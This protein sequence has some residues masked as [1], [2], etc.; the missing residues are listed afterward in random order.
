MNTKR[1]LSSPRTR[2]GRR[3][4]SYSNATPRRQTKTRQERI[5][6]KAQLYLENIYVAIDSLWRQAYEFP[7]TFELKKV[8]ELFNWPAQNPPNRYLVAEDV[9]GKAL[10]YLCIRS[11][12]FL[13]LLNQTSN[14]EFWET[15]LRLIFESQTSL[16][17]FALTRGLAWLEGFTPEDLAIPQIWLVP[18]QVSHPHEV[19]RGADGSLKRCVFTDDNGSSFN[20]TNITENIYDETNWDRNLPK[21]RFWPEWQP[22]PGD[23]SICP[24]DGFG[25][26]ALCHGGCGGWTGISNTACRCVAERTYDHALVEIVQMTSYNPGEPN[27]AVRAVARIKK[28]EYIGEYCGVFIPYDTNDLPQHADSIYA[29][30][31][32][33][34][35]DFKPYTGQIILVNDESRDAEP[36]ATLIGGKY[37][38]WPKFIN[39]KGDDTHNVE[40]VFVPIGGKMRIV[41]Q[42]VKDIRAGEELVT[43]YG[44]QYFTHSDRVRKR[45][46]LN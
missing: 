28:R 9:L 24:P 16:G 30:E 4:P 41:L 15:L 11:E 39:H 13:K 46:R 33:P 31:W 6:D 22:F 7:A 38:S 29:F 25:P 20:M 35:P 17:Q 14:N 40:F 2:S 5:D 34:T 18:A 23:P 19:Y 43:P 44:D 32:E 26:P 12:S 45:Q 42:A 8:T 10:L 21:P 1:P 36:V 37:G 27:R 3:A